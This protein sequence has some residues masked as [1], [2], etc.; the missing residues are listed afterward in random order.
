MREE[1]E[2][3]TGSQ[4]TWL[5]I[6]AQQ[7]SQLC[8]LGQRISPL[9]TSVLFYKTRGQDQVVT[10]TSEVVG[11]YRLMSSGGLWQD[12]KE[13]NIDQER[14]NNENNGYY[15]LTKARFSSGSCGMCFRRIPYTTSLPHYAVRFVKGRASVP[16][17]LAHSAHSRLTTKIVKD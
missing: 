11:I 15:C 14:S 3:R 2:H 12:V 10:A 5:L 17:H 1:E 6:P 9:C 13:E 4:N 7:C 8:D 16:Q